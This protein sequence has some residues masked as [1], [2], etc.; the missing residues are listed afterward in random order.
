MLQYESGSRDRDSAAFSL[1][2][3]S[4]AGRSSA[5]KLGLKMRQYNA[6]RV[7]DTIPQHRQTAPQSI[8][9]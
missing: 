5:W 1:Q 6:F 9:R 8:R 4:I 7:Q 2:R 3:L